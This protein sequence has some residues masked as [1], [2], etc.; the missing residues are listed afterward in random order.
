MNILMLSWEYP[1]QTVGGLARHVQ[2]ISRAL[3]GKG[4]KVA[5]IT[6]GDS[7]LPPDRSI[8]N[9]SVYLAQSYPLQPLDFISTIQHLNFSFIE[10]SIKLINSWGKIDLVHAHDWLTAYAAR[11]LKHV[12]R[13]PLVCTIHATEWGRNYGLHN[14]IQRY[15]SSVEWWLTYEA[16]KV[17]VCSRMMKNEVQE[18]FGLPEDK[19]EIIGN[20]VEPQEFNLTAENRFP[21]AKYALA[22][23]KIVFFIG[24]LVREKGV[25]TLLEAAPRILASQPKAKFIIAGDGSWKEELK[26]MA[27]L[28]G[29]REKVIFLGYV[30]DEERNTLYSYADLAVFPSLYEPFGIVALEGMAARVPVVAADTGGLGEL[31][32]HEVNGLKFK[33]GDSE[34]L[35]NQ[36]IRLLADPRLGEGMIKRA[37]EDVDNYSWEGIAQKTLELYRKIIVK[38]KANL[39]WLPPWNK[40]DESFGKIIRRYDL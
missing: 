34:S 5:V 32:R 23:E 18:L 6:S 28:S 4:E 39:S 7:C 30:G 27:V 40:K 26:E 36:V 2:G 14:D 21:R 16:W 35:A 19:L 8:N 24:R 38:S 12:Y 13:I 37:R 3:A 10:Q 15:I 20:G 29:L 9:L 1:P 31:I 17:I 33:P 25:Q 11:V 22:E